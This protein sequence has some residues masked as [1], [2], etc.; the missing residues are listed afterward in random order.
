MGGTAR[1]ELD[2]S[3][4][5]PE[6]VSGWCRTF[7]Q[8]EPNKTGPFENDGGCNPR[9]LPPP[10][11]LHQPPIMRIQLMS[12]LHLEIER[13]DELDYDKFDIPPLAPILALLG[14]IG[15]VAD[16]RLFSFV[17]KQLEKFETVLYVLGNHESYRSTYVSPSF[18]PFSISVAVIFQA[19]LN[20]VRPA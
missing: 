3:S 5:L 4:L 18:P 9:R 14:D 10:D 20:I 8:P 11:P 2:D 16:G 12:D 19:D 15:V 7:S 13:G 1:N 6:R 17:R